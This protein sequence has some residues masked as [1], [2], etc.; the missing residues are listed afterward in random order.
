MNPDNLF[1]RDHDSLRREKG[2]A[3][4]LTSLNLSYEVKLA[5]IVHSERFWGQLS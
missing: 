5:K 3:T 1:T 2:L 4:C